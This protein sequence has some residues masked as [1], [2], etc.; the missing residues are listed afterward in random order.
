[1][2][3]VGVAHDSFRTVDEDQPGAS[4]GLDQPPVAGRAGGELR[5]QRPEELL[6][7]GE[8]RQGPPH[9]VNVEDLGRTDLIEP[10]REAAERP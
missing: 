3:G 2:V 6:I 1:M 10:V 8:F 7:G 4:F 5:D 9:L